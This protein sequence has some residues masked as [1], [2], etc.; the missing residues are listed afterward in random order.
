M[1]FPFEFLNNFLAFSLC[2]SFYDAFASH[3][4]YLLLL[5]LPSDSEED[6]L[7]LASSFGFFTGFFLG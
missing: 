4:L 2:D 3:F 6:T 7:T 1:N 5:E